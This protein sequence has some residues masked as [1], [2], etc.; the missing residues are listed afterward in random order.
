MNKYKQYFGLLAVLALVFMT[1]TSMVFAKNGAD[2]SSFD[3]RGGMM[4]DERKEFK[5]GMMVAREDWK[6][7][8]K[9]MLDD[10][11][12]RR[13]EWKQEMKERMGDMKIFARMGVLNGLSHV[14]ENFIRIADKIESRM[15]KMKDEG[16]DIGDA[17][18]FLDQ[19][20][21]KLDGIKSDIEDLKT[22]IDEDSTLEEI[23]TAISGIKEDLKTAHKLLWSAVKEL[24]GEKEVGD[25]NN[26]GENN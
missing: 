8:R 20:G 22:S 23:K 3:D 10:M 21:D 9:D 18:T 19:A 12:E 16:K 2:D 4:K 15:D 25:D 11:K 6:E 13:E 24:K 5:A 17:E 1:S 7:H 14:T 26:E